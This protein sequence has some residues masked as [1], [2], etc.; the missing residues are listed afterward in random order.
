[1]KIISKRPVTLIEMVIAL[2]LTVIILTSLTYFYRQMSEIDAETERVIA[3]NFKMRFV[4]TRLADVLPR[5][6]S[7]SDKKKDFV[8]FS[9][10]DDG[11]TKSG[12]QSLIFTFDN[13]VSLDKPFSNHVLGRLYL[14]QNGDLTLAYWPSPK[15]WKD[16]TLPPMKKEVLLKG[17]E[18]LSF[19]FYIAP[20][21]KK[22]KKPANKPQPS[23]DDK[24]NEKKNENIKKPES[25]K[26]KETAKD[27]SKKN[28]NDQE[29]TTENET[30]S[31][32][33]PKGAW[34]KQPWL[35]EFQQLPAM[36]KI[37]V[38]LPKDKKPIVFAFPLSNTQTPIL[39]EQ[40]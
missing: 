11:L 39:Y 21:N 25:I 9:T 18:N 32:P 6:I 40:K 12:S 3:D 31:S 29:Q 28:E 1:M 8:F 37:I 26:D 38:T 15:R 34:R 2:A 27:E 4:E 35:S 16:N 22:A 10:G 13:K 24:T 17:V 7:E 19:E 20:E 5:S 14:S 33:E 36:I 23:N 30:G